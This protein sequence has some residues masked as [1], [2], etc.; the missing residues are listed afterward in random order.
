MSKKLENKIAV[1]T[2]GNSGIGFETARRFIEEGAKVIITGRSQTQ[3][4]DALAKINNTNLIGIQG[5]V[6]NLGDLDRLYD[7]VKTRFG[8]LDI[9]FANAGVSNIMPLESITE[10]HFD[11]HFNINVKGMLFSVQKALP[12]MKDG[13][14]IILNS[15]IMSSSGIPAF[16]VYSATKAAIRSFARTWTAELKG[17]KIRV[18]AI[19]PGPIVTPIFGKMGLNAEQQSEFAAHLPE[20][21][22]MGRMGNPEEIAST[23]LFLASDESS[24]ISGIELPVDGG[25]AQV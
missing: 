11:M 8:H 9:L 22:P 16:S 2:G 1:I 20:Q 18:N 21:I 3:L 23:V 6:S 19:S 24:Y 25:M 7:E 14:S 12:L 13:G 10:E 5:D 4:D 17:R 15:S